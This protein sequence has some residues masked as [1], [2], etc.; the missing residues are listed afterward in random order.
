MRNTIR[1]LFPPRRSRISLPGSTKLA[2]CCDFEAALNALTN[3][4]RPL[5]ESHEATKSFDIFSTNMNWI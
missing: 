2:L 3:V 1:T 4:F 5:N